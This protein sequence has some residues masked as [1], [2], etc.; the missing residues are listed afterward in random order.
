MCVY[1]CVCNYIYIYVKIPSLL[2]G[3]GII[4]VSVCVCYYI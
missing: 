3:K 4:Y 2:N 1:V